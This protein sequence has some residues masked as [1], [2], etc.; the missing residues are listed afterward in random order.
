MS[1]KYSERVIPEPIRATINPETG[2]DGSLTSSHRHVGSVGNEGSSLHD[3][4]L[5]SINLHF[6]LKDK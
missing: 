5:L 6:E 2:V 3:R 1:R 4:F